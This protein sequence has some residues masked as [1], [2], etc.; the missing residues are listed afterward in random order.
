MLTT[1]VLNTIC[2][3]KQLQ[4]EVKSRG[5]LLC[6]I[7]GLE[8]EQ[9]LKCFVRQQSAMNTVHPCISE[10]EDLLSLIGFEKQELLEHV[11]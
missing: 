6:N 7:K 3:E 8:E 11:I 9:V 5:K 1:L 10:T 2:A 4:L